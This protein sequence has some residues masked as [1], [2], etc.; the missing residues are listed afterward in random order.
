MTVNVRGFCFGCVVVKQ[1]KKGNKEE[2]GEAYR[3]GHGIV[4]CEAELDS[5]Y[6]RPFDWTGLDCTEALIVLGLKKHIEQLL[7]V[8][9]VLAFSS[10]WVH[11]HLT[12]KKSLCFFLLFQVQVCQTAV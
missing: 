11:Q 4:V 9:V 8:L 1:C 5:I 10:V 2:S 12:L 6:S 7:H 3:G